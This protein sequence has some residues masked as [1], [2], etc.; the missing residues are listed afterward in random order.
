MP[1]QLQEYL[2]FAVET[3]YLAGRLTLGY[4]QGGVHALRAE[5]K[6]DHSP[7]TVADRK[8]EELIRDRIA[9]CYAGH[10]IVGEEFGTTGSEGASHRWFIDPIDGTKA[11]ARGVPLYAVLLGLEIEGQVRA[12]AAYYPALDEMLAGAT[13]HGCWWNG[14][15][16]RVSKVQ[17][18]DE[19]YV[20]FSDAAGFAAHGRARAWERLQAATYHRIGWSDA[21]GYLLV[22][23]GRIEIML[24]PVM[25]AWDCGPFPPILEE[26]GG[27]FGDWQGNRTIYA[28]EALCTTQALL[29]QVLELIQTAGPDEG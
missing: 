13:G 28:G 18:L 17:R 5:L 2:D 21:Y 29:P 10:A 12:G 20:S 3:A 26:A 11:F 1:D 7:V 8:A 25:N 16:A 22:A 15:R 23:T 4:Y 9:A 6:A 27:Y 19:A 24:D 14:R